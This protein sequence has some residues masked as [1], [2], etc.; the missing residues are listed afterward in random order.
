[1]ALF[2]LIHE[3]ARSSRDGLQSSIAK[4]PGASDLGPVCGGVRDSM[5]MAV[6]YFIFTSYSNH[7]HI[8][9]PLPPPPPPP[10]HLL[11]TYRS[12]Y[13]D[14]LCPAT[15]RSPRCCT[16]ATRRAS[17]KNNNNNYYYNYNNHSSTHPAPRDI[18]APINPR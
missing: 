1:V 6:A 18:F 10:L 7:H 3:G 16:Q 4:G 12:G 11:A 8:T 9:P 14:W 15:I 2:P 13:R 5:A 17:L